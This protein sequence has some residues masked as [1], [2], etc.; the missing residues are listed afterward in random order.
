MAR[1]VEGERNAHAAISS[2]L[3]A[4]PAQKPVRPIVQ[5][6]V[7]GVSMVDLAAQEAGIIFLK[8]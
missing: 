4:Q 8:V 1:R 6:P 2:R 5:T 3:R 7:H